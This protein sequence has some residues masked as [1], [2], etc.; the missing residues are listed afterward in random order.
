MQINILKYFSA[1]IFDIY[2]KL[3]KYIKHIV[4]R[5]KCMRDI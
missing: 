2:M 4:R 3:N 5:K 1:M